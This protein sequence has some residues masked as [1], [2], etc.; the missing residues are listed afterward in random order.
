MIFGRYDSILIKSY[1]A[2]TTLFYSFFNGTG[3]W[4][5]IHFKKNIKIKQYLYWIKIS[6]DTP[7][8]IDKNVFYF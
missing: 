5:C 4:L 3:V 6:F 1:P 7:A 2:H 8:P